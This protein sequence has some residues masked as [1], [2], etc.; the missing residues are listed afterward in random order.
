MAAR[1]DESTSFHDM[2]VLAPAELTA[3]VDG[4]DREVARL[5]RHLGTVEQAYAFVR[6][7]I[8]F[9][10]SRPA[11]KPAETLQDGRASCLGKAALLASLYRAL[12]MDD[13]ALRVVTGQVYGKEG[14]IEHAWLELEQGA[15]CLQQDPSS[16]LGLF[17]FDEFKGT[18]YTQAFVRRELFCF[19]DA[20]FAVVSQRN[21]FRETAAGPD[22]SAPVTP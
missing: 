17:R 9:D 10:P 11:G 8:A 3:L 4:K 5:A 21:R 2:R 13:S 7:R 6:D 22:P 1:D 20:G 19:N 18:D 14:L 15:Q 16:L 12:G